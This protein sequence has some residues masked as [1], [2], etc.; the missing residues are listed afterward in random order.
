MILTYGISSSSTL[1]ALN[2]NFS[3]YNDVLTGSTSNILATNA[4]FHADMAGNFD[5]L[6]TLCNFSDEVISYGIRGSEYRR[7]I[8]DNFDKLKQ[9]A[10]SISEIQNKTSV[11]HVDAEAGDTINF[12]IKGFTGQPQIKLYWG[13]NTYET[14]LMDSTFIRKIKTYS[15]AMQCD[16]IIVNSGSVQGFISLL[17]DSPGNLAMYSDD[18]FPKNLSNM[19]Y[20][21]MLHY[22]VRNNRLWEGDLSL[23]TKLTYLHTDG[24][25]IKFSGNIASWINLES[26]FPGFYCIYHG[27]LANNI[28]LVSFYGGQKTTVYG[29]TSLLNKLKQ[30]EVGSNFEPGISGNTVSPVLGI[31]C[32]AG[33]NTLNYD[34]TNHLN[35]GYIS[36]VLN[37]TI[38][39]DISNC[40]KL[41][42]LGLGGPYGGFT[43]ALDNLVNLALC[44]YSPNN[45][46]TK[47]VRMI[48]MPQIC[49]LVGPHPTWH[50]TSSEI[51]QLL[52][53]LWA[54]RDVFRRPIDENGN[55]WPDYGGIGGMRYI[56]ISGAADSQPPTG[57]GLTDL[58]NLRNYITPP[59]YL[60]TKWTIL[61][62]E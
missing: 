24:E 31:L 39:G 1:E 54:N 62:P 35:I 6:S 49:W 53:D 44:Y 37:N 33:V 12:S 32:Y 56:D 34:F 23:A 5:R 27:N 13:D 14:V 19:T 47:P 50:F 43:G 22:G 16:I 57:Q 61:V 11:I 41:Y 45:V 7:I 21:K 51:N 42:Y 38:H 30:L 29:N 59:N 20:I 28:N 10:F 52:A 2:S 9:S 46:F 40:I 3:Y 55:Q 4:N 36:A 15:L 8:N 26:F 58:A 60:D 25:G 17:S 48:N 18:S